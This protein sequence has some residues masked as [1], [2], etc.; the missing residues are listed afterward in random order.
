MQRLRTVLV[1]NLRSRYNLNA[2]MAD[3]SN[4]L[5][6]TGQVEK[7]VRSMKEHLPVEL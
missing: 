6:A 1:D 5:S 3:R 4:V 7:L 2:A